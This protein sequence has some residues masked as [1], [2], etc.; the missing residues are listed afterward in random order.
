MAQ[1]VKHQTLGLG[2]GGDLTVGSSP[3]SGFALNVESA[4]DSL[5]PSLPHS[6]SL[7]LK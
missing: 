2:S 6:H 1:L 5:F 4:S 3:A 7:S